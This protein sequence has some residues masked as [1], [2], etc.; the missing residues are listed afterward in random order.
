M[1][2]IALTLLTSLDGVMQSPGSTD[3]PFKYRGWTLDFDLG[4]EGNRFKLEEARNAEALLLGRVTYEA[5]QAFWPTAE[6][7]YADRLNELP[8]VRRLLDAHRPGLECDRPGRRLAGGSAPTAGGARRRHP[9]LWQPP[10]FA[11]TD[12]DG[13]GGRAAPTGLP[14]GAR[15]GR[16]PVR[17]DAGQDRA[18][19]GRIAS[20]R[21]R[22][23]EH[24]LCTCH[25]G[26]VM[27]TLGINSREDLRPIL[28][29][30]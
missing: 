9:R 11:G 1:G 12:R 19:S 23:G 18:A 21:G 4:P 25:G 29:Q 28:R 7:E 16:S 27:R 2:K 22:R 5:M 15:Y 26:R 17:G 24:D 8:K 10:P 20:V 3:V 14:G 6:G 13:A 30:N